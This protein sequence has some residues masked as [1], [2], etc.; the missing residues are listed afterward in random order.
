MKTLLYALLILSLFGCEKGKVE[1]SSPFD[2]IECGTWS[3]SKNGAG[4]CKYLVAILIPNNEQGSERWVTSNTTIVIYQNSK[5]N[6]Y[7]R[8]SIGNIL[9]IQHKTSN[10]DESFIDVLPA[11]VY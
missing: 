7:Y 6:I 2:L 10:H 1:H 9:E 4:N 11:T 8:D 5:Y 3:I